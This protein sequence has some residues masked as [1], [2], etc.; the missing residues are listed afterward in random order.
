[1]VAGIAVLLVSL[2]LGT[3]AGRGAALIFLAVAAAGGFALWMV[4]AM[5]VDSRRGLAALSGRTEAA[6]RAQPHGCLAMLAFSVAMVPA[7]AGPVLASLALLNGWHQLP[8]LAVMA[9]CG[10]VS[11]W[12]VQPL[13]HLT[14]IHQGSGA[15]RRSGLLGWLGG[16]V[17]LLAM[18]FGGIMDSFH[19]PLGHM[20]S[21]TWRQPAAGAHRVS[22]AEV[23]TVVD[24]VFGR[25]AHCIE[26]RPWGT[27][28]GWR[29]TAAGT[30]SWKVDDLFLLCA[31]RLESRAG[32]T[33][34]SRDSRV[35]LTSQHPMLGSGV[36]EHLFVLPFWLVA[37]GTVSVIRVANVS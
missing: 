36:S 33:P 28:E 11:F 18:L 4:L 37:G 24:Q 29:L 16:A 10:I 35:H 27:A 25:A 26:V 7:L 34:N 12:G 9:L 22:E 30:A 20:W 15:R 2:M 23:R 31:S 6:R 13:L 32:G 19:T 14:G 21:F 1:M 5:N 17:C 3:F 8:W